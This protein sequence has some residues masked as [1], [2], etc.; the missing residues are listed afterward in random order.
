MARDDS[1]DGRVAGVDLMKLSDAELEKASED[2]S[3]NLPIKNGDLVV[4]NGDIPSGK[5][6]QNVINGDK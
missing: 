4:I 1:R 3:T 5:H 6:K 2:C